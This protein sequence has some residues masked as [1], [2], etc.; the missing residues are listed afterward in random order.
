MNNPATDPTEPLSN[1]A[2]YEQALD[3]LYSFINFE[4]KKQDRYMAS[5][6]DHTRPRRL[7]EALGNPHANLPAIHIAGT[8]GKGSTAAICAFTLRAAGYTVGLYTSPH[9]QDFRERIRIL[10]P[11]DADGRISQPQFTRQI[12]K[13]R[14]L[15]N[16]FPDITWFEIL[17]AIAFLHFAEVGVDVA[18]VEVGLGGRLDATNVI[19]PLVSVITRLSLDHTEL[20]G[21]TLTQIAYEKGGIIKPGI[22][23]VTANQEPDALARLQEITQ[24]RGCGLT[25]V[26]QD[27][28]YAGNE[29]NHPTQQTLTISHSAAP[30]LIPDGTQFTL[31]LG[32]EHQLENG[33]V[34]LVAL[35]HVQK[36]F[37]KL[38]L[39]V[40]QAGFASVK[41]PGRLDL[42]HPGDAKTP[43]LL[44]D[45][46]HNPDAIRKLRDA[47]HHSFQYNRLWLIFGTPA[48]KDVPH[49]LADL[50]PLAHHTA[51]T[52]ASHPRSATP[53]QLAAIAAEL[54]FV[55]TAVPD[56][57]T[58]LTTT[59]QQAQPSDLI[60]VTGSIVVVGDLLNQWESLQSQLLANKVTH[61]S[62]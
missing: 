58:A 25:I 43:A 20:L 29:V 61:Q 12:N 9:L 26:G 38:T 32:G 13:I 23:V 17:T 3:F 39:P 6:L 18:V 2:D 37:P 34:A 56:M 11:D 33:T 54:G 22:P 47:L 41:W 36:Q 50:L 27:W 53:E 57:H 59:W 8:K 48:D 7:M 42:I 1:A 51:M 52:T 24:E 30:E 31:P 4:A 19:T 14:A 46:A 16:E 40:L 62:L 10:T 28:Q 55:V 5:K 44:V 15:E 49:M 45:C 21:N 60:C 35:Q